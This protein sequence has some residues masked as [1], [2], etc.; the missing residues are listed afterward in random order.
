M[1][2]HIHHSNLIENIDDPKEDKQS[3]I[4][5]Q[6]LLQQK[7]LN[8][9][10]ICRVQKIITLKQNLLPHQRG[11]YRNVSKVNVTVGKSTTPHFFIVPHLMNNWLLDLSKYP[12]LENH[13]RFEH[14]HPFVDGNGRTGR[15]L[16]WWQD[17]QKGSE[18]RFFDFAKRE[19][20]YKLFQPSKE[21][22]SY[23]FQQSRDNNT[24]AW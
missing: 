23:N 8:H 17:I 9:D 21:N 20:Y 3:L 11:Y 1:E 13:I 4:A 15:M 7:E 5:W 6:Y 18:P 14:I 22:K 12:P 16:C 19:A 24:E 10:V 2:Q